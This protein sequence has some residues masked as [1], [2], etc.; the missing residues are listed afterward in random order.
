[1]TGRKVKANPTLTDQ[2]L[3]DLQ[4][5]AWFMQEHCEVVTEALTDQDTRREIVQL[6]NDL[7]DLLEVI[8]ADAITKKKGS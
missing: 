4:R 6:I 8:Q 2:L 3:T 5:C 1:M 7:D